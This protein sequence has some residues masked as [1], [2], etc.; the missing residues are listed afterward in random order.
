MHCFPADLPF[1]VTQADT[2]IETNG[3]TSYYDAVMAL[4]ENV[5]DFYRLYLAP[6]LGHCSGGYG[7]YPDGIFDSTLAWVEEGVVPDTLNAT[8]IGTVPVV[9]RPLCPY[10]KKQYHDGKGNSMIG[11]GFYC[12]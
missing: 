5:H 1:L 9:S 7:A 6:G 4:D 12:E 2:L 11:E 10:P 8:S 3:T